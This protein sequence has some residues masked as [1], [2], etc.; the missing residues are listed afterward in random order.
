VHNGKDFDGVRLRSI[1]Q[2]IGKAREL[3]FVDIANNL[4]IL[5]GTT[6]NSVEGIF[7]NV[8]KPLF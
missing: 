5:L 3:T 6:E 2:T 8:E 7:E 4:R 1:D